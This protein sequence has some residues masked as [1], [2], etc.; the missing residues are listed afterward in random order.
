M[1]V[2]VLS[3]DLLVIGSNSLK[4]KRQVVRS[5]LDGIRN[6][7]NVSAAELDSLDSRRRAVIGFACVSN[8]RIVANTILNKVLTVVESD[9]RAAVEGCRLEF[10]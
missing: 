8:D 5:L 1:I 4:D 7:F 3:V 10:L 6:R 9:P 2:G